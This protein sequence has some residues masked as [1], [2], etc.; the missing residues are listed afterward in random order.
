[1][2]VPGATVRLLDPQDNHVEALYLCHG[3]KSEASDDAPPAHQEP[4]REDESL[5]MFPFM[6]E[7]PLHTAVA[8]K[9]DGVIQY[10]VR[11]GAKVNI[12]N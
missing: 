10:L 9:R 7:T 4:R 5:Y 1:M 3:V 8:V 2:L 12:E 6:T 11:K